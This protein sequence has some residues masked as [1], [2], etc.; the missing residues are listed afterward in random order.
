[1]HKQSDHAHGQSSTVSYAGF[2]IPVIVFTLT[3]PLLV[4]KIYRAGVSSGP[5]GLLKTTIDQSATPSTPV[6]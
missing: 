3:Y 4:V 5:N 2:T 1:M 6:P